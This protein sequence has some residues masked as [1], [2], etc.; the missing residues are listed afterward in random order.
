MARFG[1]VSL[2]TLT[3]VR[4]PRVTPEKLAGDGVKKDKI[5]KESVVERRKRVTGQHMLPGWE[6]LRSELRAAVLANN[7][8]LVEDLRR[9]A[10]EGKR[11]AA[12]A[13]VTLPQM[14]RRGGRRGGARPGNGRKPM[15]FSQLKDKRPS[16]VRPT[17]RPRPRLG[18]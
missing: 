3:R 2:R 5:P 1:S 8:A 13:G 9:L 4:Q 10:A 12:E 18:A 16:R 7:V 11:L 17:K 15:P 6:R 14:D